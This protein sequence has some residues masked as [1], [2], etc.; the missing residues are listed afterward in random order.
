[1]YEARK[2]LNVWDMI[3]YIITK[4]ISERRW[5]IIYFITPL[6]SWEG[7]KVC[8]T[9]ASQGDREFITRVTAASQGDKEFIT[10]VKEKHVFAQLISLVIM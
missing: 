10:R 3:T 5:V 9:A 4:L 2:L 7:D 8:V 1:M 6:F